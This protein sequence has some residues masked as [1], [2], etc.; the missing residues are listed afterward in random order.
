MNA[1]FN[2]NNIGRIAGASALPVCPARLSI[3]RVADACVETVAN[4]Q[5]GFFA[6]LPNLLL[7][8]AKS[9]FFQ[10]SVIFIW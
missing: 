1:G 9:A 4:I 10:Q 2:L 6:T 3:G 7:S 8:A 5:T